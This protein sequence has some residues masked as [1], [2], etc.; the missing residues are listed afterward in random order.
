MDTDLSTV[1]CPDCGVTGSIELTTRLVAKPIGTF[2][3][4]GAQMKVSAVETPVLA[5]TTPGCGLVKYPKTD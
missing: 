3:L 4:A 1:T 5:C 2:S